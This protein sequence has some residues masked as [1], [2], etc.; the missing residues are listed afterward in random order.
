[1]TEQI[2]TISRSRLVTVAGRIDEA[3]LEEIRG[4]LRD[5]LNLA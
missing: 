4:W 5:F 1:M 3:T 2:R